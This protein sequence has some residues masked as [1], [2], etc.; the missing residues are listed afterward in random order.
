MLQENG[1]WNF[2]AFRPYRVLARHPPD[3]SAWRCAVRIGPGACPSLGAPSLEKASSPMHGP[4]VTP[5][6]TG[7]NAVKLII[8]DPAVPLANNYDALE[9][10]AKLNSGR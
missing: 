7:A 2:S 3:L 4:S 1:K 5:E 8:S 6:Q 9:P 10:V